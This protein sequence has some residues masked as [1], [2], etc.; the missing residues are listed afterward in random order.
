MLART[1]ALLAPRLRALA[2]TPSVR[3]LA[4]DDTHSDFMPQ[5]KPPPADAPADVQERI[6]QDLAKHPLVVFMKGVPSAPQCGFSNRVVQI[7]N[8]EGVEDFKSYNVLA[9]PDLREGIKKYSAWP[10]IP[11]V[12]I[13]GEFQGGSD[14]MLEMYQSGELSQKLKDAGVPLREMASS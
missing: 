5:R 6:A 8:A 7:L 10:T 14:V 2:A 1:G 13:K 12:Y 9:D 4:T 11:Q 3:R